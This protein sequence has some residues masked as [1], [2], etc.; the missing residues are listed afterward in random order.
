M[1]PLAHLDSRRQLPLT[2]GQKT[3]RVPIENRYSFTDLGELQAFWEVASQKGRCTISL[4]P[5][6]KGKMEVSLPPNVSAGSLLVIRFL[7]AKGT[8]ITAHGVTL[9]DL[10]VAPP[11]RP[12]AGCPEWQDDGQVIAIRGNDFRL[13]MVRATGEFEQDQDKASAALL[14]FPRIFVTRR[15]D[16]NVFNPGGLPMPSIPT[17]AAA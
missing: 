16:R 10:P 11:P 15:E 7:D 5:Q 6:S 1:H 8:L 9:G 13:K 17:R 3:V 2:P 14:Q 12:K 4:P